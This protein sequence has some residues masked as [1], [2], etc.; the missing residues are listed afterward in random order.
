MFG[1]NHSEHLPGLSKGHTDSSQFAITTIL[2]TLEKNVSAYY[3]YFLQ[4]S[5]LIPTKASEKN[6]KPFSK[7][8]LDKITIA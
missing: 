6:K 3:L 7:L 2:P 8:L 4:P 1:Q 5:E